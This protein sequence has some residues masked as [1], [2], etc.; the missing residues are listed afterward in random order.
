MGTGFYGGFGNTK[1]K[2][3][4]DHLLTKLELSGVKFSKENIVMITETQE[5]ELV[6]LEKGNRFAGLEHIILRHETDIFQK[7]G[8]TKDE[9]P[10]FIKEIIE[11]G[12]L[13]HRRPN[14]NGIERI[15]LYNGK[16][17]IL[18]GVGNN[19]FIVTIYPIGDI[20]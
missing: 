1:G 7:F 12:E 5:G 18:N 11:N 19:G 2:L 6:W 8:V 13:I 17:Y 16:H 4:P 9:I 20:K 10:A 3:I 15:Y 14:K